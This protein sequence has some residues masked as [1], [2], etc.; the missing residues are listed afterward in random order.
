MWKA[1]VPSIYKHL[2][3]IFIFSLSDDCVVLLLHSRQAD[4]FDNYYL[5]N[6]INSCHAYIINNWI[7]EKVYCHFSSIIGD[8][9]IWCFNNSLAN[10][11]LTLAVTFN[12]CMSSICLQTGINFIR[13]RELGT[14]RVFGPFIISILHCASHQIEGMIA[15]NLIFGCPKSHHRSDLQKKLYETNQIYII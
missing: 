3:L 7:E 14:G 13:G 10:R 4:W 1:Q 9:N 8:K 15:S 2:Q 5:L 6:T 11:S 12:W